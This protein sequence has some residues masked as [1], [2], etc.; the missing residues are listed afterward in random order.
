MLK[1]YTTLWLHIHRY[2]VHHIFYRPMVTLSRK[3]ERYLNN[4]LYFLLAVRFILISQRISVRNLSYFDVDLLAKIYFNPA[5]W[6]NV[7]PMEQ[8]WPLLLL[9]YVIFI[10][11]TQDA[12]NVKLQNKNNIIKTYTLAVYIDNIDDTFQCNKEYVKY[13]TS[14]FYH[15]RWSK[16]VRHLYRLWTNQEKLKHSGR[17]RYFTLLTSKD[18]TKMF[19]M[20]I[21]AEVLCT[22]IIILSWTLSISIG[23]HYYHAAKAYDLQVYQ[24]MLIL[25]DYL[26]LV[27]LIILNSFGVGTVF[28]AFISGTISGILYI[29]RARRIL[30]RRTKEKIR[31]LWRFMYHSRKVPLILL[32]SHPMWT[33][34]LTVFIITNLSLNV[35]LTVYFIKY[36]H[37]VTIEFVVFYLVHSANTLLPMLC[38]AF[39]SNLIHEP[40]HLLAS[41][42]AA[43]K[44]PIRLPANVLF[45]WKLCICYEVMH[46]ERPIG[47][48]CLLGTITFEGIFK[49][50]YVYICAILVAIQF[51]NSYESLS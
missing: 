19:L 34:V 20:H 40:A 36:G 41:T 22:T 4:F 38:A 26:C 46:T 49:A 7:K 11:I 35:F 8:I 21:A 47:M 24:A 10:G 37:L 6:N 32:D 17:L 31:Q 42:F 44:F 9:T 28:T 30:A 12:F 25:S 33:N 50:I 14:L 1:R 13:L 43:N 45:H 39:Q 48:Q 2:E 5:D 27:Y 18:R 51:M 29:K 16:L 23:V 3:L 15:L